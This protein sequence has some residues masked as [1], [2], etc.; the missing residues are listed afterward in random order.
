M[1]AE[2]PVL[3]IENLTK[4]YGEFTALDS[5][6]LS[7]DKGQILGLIGPNGAGKTTT[8]KI[9]VGLQKPTSGR[10]T[11]AGADCVRDAKKIK[12][13]VGY[14]PDKFGSYE[15]MRVREYLD[16]FGAAFGISRRIRNKRIDEVMDTTGTTYMKD[17]FVDSLSHG[18]GQR[19]GIAR[20][21]IH[22]PEVIIL[23]EP[24]NGLDP[25]ARIEM[26]ELLLRLAAMGKTLLVTSHILPELARI[27]N[28]AAIMT[29]GKLRAYGTV[30]EI[31]RQVSQQRLIEVQ[32]E[33]PS[34]VEAAATAIRQGLEEGAEVTPAPNESMVRFRTARPE[35]ELGAL[36][37][38]LV[39]AGLRVTQFREVQTDLEDAFMTFARPNQPAGGT[40]RP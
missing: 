27:C 35:A 4:K 13:L 38:K 32:L 31:G 6:T 24:A 20:T 17:K 22:D 36:L 18:M 5:M 19:V 11:I 33:N 28:R 16:F 2:R 26:R 23:D 21:L 8:I 12:H 1:A 37:A 25:Q 40:N 9:L 15:N 14:M 34:Q 10:A 30:E 7:V 39:H 29:H 3:E